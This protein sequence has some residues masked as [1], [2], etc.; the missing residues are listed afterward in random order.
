MRPPRRGERGWGQVKPADPGQL[1]DRIRAAVVRRQ[2]W[3]QYAASTVAL[4][5][6]I[7][8]VERGRAAAK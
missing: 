7:E 6:A 3:R 8:L 5:E 2:V 1:A 4:A